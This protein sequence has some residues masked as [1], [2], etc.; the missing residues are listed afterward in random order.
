LGGGK[1]DV[2][3]SA[4]GRFLENNF[5][6]LKAISLLGQVVVDE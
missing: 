1:K 2:R 4:L 3:G 5:W 6:S